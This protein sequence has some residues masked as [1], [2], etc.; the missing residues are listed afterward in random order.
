MTLTPEGEG[1]VPRIQ[2]SAEIH[3]ADIKALE[4]MGFSD[5]LVK[6][7]KQYLACAAF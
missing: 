6:P 4:E 2:E 5:C 7:N 3:S 1:P